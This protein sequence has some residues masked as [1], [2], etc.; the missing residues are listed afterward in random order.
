MA[1]RCCDGGVSPL[2]YR[3]LF[4]RRACDCCRRQRCKGRCGR[5]RGSDTRAWRPAVA[6]LKAVMVLLSRCLCCLCCV[7][8]GLTSRATP[9]S[10]SDWMSRLV[11]LPCC[12]GCS[13][14][15]IVASGAEFLFEHLASVSR[16]RCCALTLVPR[17]VLLPRGRPRIVVAGRSATA[18]LPAAWLAPQRVFECCAVAA[19]VCR[20]C[21]VSCTLCAP[22]STTCA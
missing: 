2:L 11:P 5:R 8:H 15:D 16:E 18:F 17:A 21:V 22:C 12:R 13:L 4:A 9:I 19:C 6:P 20:C 14:A 7:V 3:G 10:L 1:R